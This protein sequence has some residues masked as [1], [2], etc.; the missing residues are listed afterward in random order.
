MVSSILSLSWKGLKLVSWPEGTAEVAKLRAAS[1]RM[2]FW[3]LSEARFGTLRA[4]LR[5]L[6]TD[7]LLKAAAM[8]EPDQSEQGG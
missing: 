6:P 8:A 5:N 2:S 4:L 7:A 3:L 1:L